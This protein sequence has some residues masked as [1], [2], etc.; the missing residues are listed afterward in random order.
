MSKKKSKKKIKYPPLPKH[1]ELYGKI[2]D[3]EH[4]E[5]LQKASHKF[6]IE[7]ERIAK[8]VVEDY[9]KNPPASGSENTVVQVHQDSPYISEKH[10]KTALKTLKYV[11]IKKEKYKKLNEDDGE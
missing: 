4:Y 10:Y 8:L 6:A 11:K 1:T 5:E 7:M 2:R 9:K 3:K